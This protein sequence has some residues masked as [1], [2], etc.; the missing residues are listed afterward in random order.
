[1][2]DHLRSEASSEFGSRFGALVIRSSLWL[3]LGGWLGAWLLFAVGVAPTAFRVLPSSEIAGSL[4][5]P[6]RWKATWFI[7]SD[8]RCHSRRLL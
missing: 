4:V 3:V 5:S 6:L 8:Q 2:N 7:E 1:M